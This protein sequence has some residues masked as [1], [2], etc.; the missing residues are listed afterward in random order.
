MVYPIVGQFDYVIARVSVGD[1]V[2]L[3]D[4][5]DRQRPFH[6]LPQRALNHNGLSIQDGRCSWI[7][8]QPCASARSSTFANFAIDGTGFLK[9][10][11]RRTFHDYSAFDQRRAL[12]GEQPDDTSDRC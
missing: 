1:K 12:T 5:T 6:L 10:L 7:D 9:G 2:Y 8:I 11:V 3:L 4:A